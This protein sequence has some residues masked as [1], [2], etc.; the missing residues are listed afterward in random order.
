MGKRIKRPIKMRTFQ[1]CQE[2][3]MFYDDARD[4]SYAAYYKRLWKRLYEKLDT[5]LLTKLLQIQDKLDAI[6]KKQ[7][8]KDAA[9][10]Q[11]IINQSKN[12]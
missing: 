5:G 11:N 9:E 4:I 7:K 3:N 12:K 10:F 1:Y 8:V 6:V 2:R